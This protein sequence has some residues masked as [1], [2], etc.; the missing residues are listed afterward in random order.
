M[1]ILHQK[2][3]NKKSYPA[4]DLLFEAIGKT[5]EKNEKIKQE[6]KE[7]ETKNKNKTITPDETKR[8]A[9]LLK[10]IKP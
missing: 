2:S 3:N 5:N 8:L 1:K 7:L 10:S 4:G 6:I 9:E